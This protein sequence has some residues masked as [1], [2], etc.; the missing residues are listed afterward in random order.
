MLRCAEFVQK[1]TRTRSCSVVRCCAVKFPHTTIHVENILW[2]V[3]VV[4]VR[5]DFNN[6]RDSVP[7]KLL[8]APLDVFAVQCKA[9]ELPATD[10]SG[11]V[12]GDDSTIKILHF[13]GMGRRAFAVGIRLV[14]R[15]GNSK[16]GTRQGYKRISHATILEL[17]FFTQLCLSCLKALIC[18]SYVVFPKKICTMTAICG[19]VK[20]LKSSN[21]SGMPPSKGSDGGIYGAP[22]FPTRSS[23]PLLELRQGYKRKASSC[24]RCFLSSHTSTSII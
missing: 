4:A 24:L 10:A 23:K 22:T 12:G 15:N 19:M 5:W 13:S 14:L 6:I 1:G 21:Q 2:T 17:S 20:C 18:N 9:D 7:N 16:V 3:H 11:N 8:Q